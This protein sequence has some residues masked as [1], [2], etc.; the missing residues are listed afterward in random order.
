MPGGQPA[1]AG[2]PAT[3]FLNQLRAAGHFELAIEYLD[4]L[5][6]YPG[7]A[8]ELIAAVSME[9]AQT[10]IDAAV[11]ARQNDQREEL[12]GLAE[13]QLQKF[14]QSDPHPR[15]SQARMQLGRLQMVRAAQLQSSDSEDQQALARESYLAA[16]GT[17]DSI[18]TTL[19]ETLK[20]IQ[21]ANIDPA[22][23]PEQ[24]AQ[25]DQYRV[26]FLEA[27]K[28]S[29]EARLLAAQ[30]FDNPH[31]DAKQELEKSLETLNELVDKY[32]AYVQGAIAL[33]IRGEVQTELGATDEA[34]DSFIRMLEQP[35]VDALREAK[36]RAVVGMIRVFLAKSPPEYQN[37]IDRGQAQIQELRPDEKNLPIVQTLR[38]SLAK[39]YLAK[40]ADT[41]NQE[42]ANMRRAT[43]AGRQLL[44]DV[45][46]FPGSQATEATQL[47]A[48]LG[49][50]VADPAQP[51]ADVEPPQNFQAALENARQRLLAAQQL[52]RS[53]QLL[54]D[55]AT[56]DPATAEQRRS[57]QQQILQANDEAIA[58]LRRG[59][60]MITPET[61][62]ALQNQARHLLAYVLYQVKDYRGAAVVG[63][64]VS[65]T[66]AGSD[67]G[68]QGGLVALNALQLL[69]ADD[70]QNDALLVELEVLSNDLVTTW[71]ADPKAA[72]AQGTMLRLALKNG[73]YQQ[74]EALIE[75]MPQGAEKQQSLQLM[76]RI[77]WNDSLT[78]R[79]DGKD[80]EA[81]QA[82]VA[83]EKSL[84]TGLEQMSENSAGPESLRAALTLAKVYL[85]LDQTDR[86]I[87][88]LDH[89]TYG[90]LR[91]VQQQGAPDGAF[92]SDLYSTELLTVVQR[93]SAPDS[94]PKPLLDRAAQA[95]DKLQNS[96]EGPDAAQRLTAIYVSMAKLIREQLDRSDPARRAKLVDAFRLFLAHIAAN[97][98][99]P[100]TLQWTAAT[101]IEL[102]ESS[103][104]PNAGAPQGQAAELLATAVTTLERLQSNTAEPSL[105]IDFQLGRAQRMLGQYKQAADTFEQLLKQKP[106]MIDA[107]I[108]AALTYEQWAA[109]VPPKFAG[110]AYQAALNGTRPDA[111]NKNTIWGWGKIGQLTMRDPKHKEI[112]FDARYHIALSRYLWG[113]ATD[114]PRIIHQAALDITRVHALHPELGGPAQYAKFDSLLKTI[115]KQLGEPAD[116]LPKS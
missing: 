21:G 38:L 52:N 8:A 14:L 35:A 6:R 95:I 11:A 2:E 24:A 7:V 85:E 111:E 58:L 20:E 71:P 53:L 110:N 90:P 28:N 88:V 62:A 1:A 93:M 16:A 91:W 49:I 5:D 97:S 81:S 9:K 47:L 73:R 60:A 80:D 98:T 50:E 37:A 63:R 87:A 12:F 72:A 18:V 106:M 89:Q 114:D 33:A 66:A 54:G 29:A 67:L 46:K 65:R 99:Q 36:F 3:D 101:L 83:A 69:L 45:S 25:R 30:T 26:E 94:D 104:Q 68:L 55:P 56:A 31:S 105:T 79:S 13:E 92:A 42:P 75:K 41:E 40:A 51:I 23:D 100:E 96:V 115:Q 103:L 112:F 74:A 4:R 102:A 76:G 15:H 86:A 27:I 113:K 64:F 78:L 34:L 39:A 17:F 22:K 70:S 10:Y 82:V 57:L 116:G 108:E 48:T 43:T 77:L 61:D 44:V 109:V 32:Q 107:Q 19:R 84:R 59:L